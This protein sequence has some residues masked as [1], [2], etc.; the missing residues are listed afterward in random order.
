LFARSGARCASTLGALFVQFA[1]QCFVF[2]DQRVRDQVLAGR[3]GS[4]GRGAFDIAGIASSCDAE[5]SM[6]ASPRISATLISQYSL[7][8]A[9]SISS[10]AA[11][12]SNPAR[13]VLETS[14]HPVRCPDGGL[15]A[16]L[17]FVFRPLVL[18]RSLRIPA[19]TPGE[20]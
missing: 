18:L 9:I 5:T 3:L 17:L 11:W 8:G 13:P 14:P 7:V 6:P 12:D 19:I 10:R 16:R 1:L 20:P 4:H 2:I 15:S